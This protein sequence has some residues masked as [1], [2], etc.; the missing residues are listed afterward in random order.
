MEDKLKTLLFVT[1]LS[2]FLAIHLDLNFLTKTAVPKDGHL[3]ILLNTGTIL[4]CR[5]TN[6]TTYATEI[7][8]HNQDQLNVNVCH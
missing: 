5:R 1:H 6:L 8:R 4:S 2:H 3:H 7:P